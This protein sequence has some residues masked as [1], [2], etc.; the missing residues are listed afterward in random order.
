MQ[1]CITILTILITALKNV[2]VFYSDEFGTLSN[3]V[4]LISYLDEYLKYVQVNGMNIIK[5]NFTLTVLE[6]VP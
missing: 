6:T 2:A 4:T 1:Q 3:R 5:N